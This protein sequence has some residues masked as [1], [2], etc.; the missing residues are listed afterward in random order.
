MARGAD[1]R[2]FACIAADSAKR[3][4]RI[5]TAE[6]DHD[7]ARANVF[8]HIITKIERR[9][10]LGVRLRG[11]GS[12]GLAHPA[13]SAQQED[14][15]LHATSANASSVFR[16]RA[17]LAAVISHNGNRHSADIAPRHESA[18]FTGT[19]FGS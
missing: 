6:I 2:W 5:W 9:R 11:G 16:S 19:G 1:N 10:D 8:R 3:V 13:F 7:V 4:G 15:R 17:W 14:A 12:D 18:V